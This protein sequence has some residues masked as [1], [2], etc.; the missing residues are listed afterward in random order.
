MIS[1][2]LLMLVTASLFITACESPVKPG[3]TQM[4]NKRLVD[5]PIISS[6]THASIGHNIQGPSLIRVPEWVANPL[7]RYYLYFADHKG[8]YIRLAY[9]DQLTGPWTVYEPG[10]LHLVNSHFL[11]EAP[12]VPEGE[13]DKVL[14]YMRN[15]LGHKGRTDQQMLDDLIVPHIASPDVHVDHNNRRIVM[16]FHGLDAFASQVSRVATSEDG[17]NF[18][19]R[20]EILGRSYMR[21]FEHQS[22]TYAMAMPG[23]FYRSA[24]GLSGFEEGPKLFGKFMR[25]SGLLKRGDTLHVFWSQVGDTPESILHSSIDISG[26][27]ADW[28]ESEAS[29]VIAP[30]RNWEG[31]D[32]PLIPSERSTAEGHVNQLRDPAIY[33]E[34]G[35]IFLLYAVAGESGIAIAE[36]FTKWQ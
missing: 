27:W 15:V 21:A 23:Q 28:K 25:H 3:D 35:R 30:E 4:R 29:L 10:A 8:S 24:D 20:N 16:Y 26:D 17:I 7:G 31:A 19:A 1:K 14:F 18:K 11:T 32:A 6:Q 12:D 13:V 33:E 34:D 2:C 5:S 22:A 36:L 9:A